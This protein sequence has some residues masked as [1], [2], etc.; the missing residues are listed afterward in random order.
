MV[1][2]YCWG[3]CAILRI[4]LRRLPVQVRIGSATVCDWRIGRCFDIKVEII[5][6]AA[7]AQAPSVIQWQVWFGGSPVYTTRE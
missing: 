7:S 2:E 5:R 3:V 4:L 1:W 6:R